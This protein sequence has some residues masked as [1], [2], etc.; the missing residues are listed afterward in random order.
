[1]SLNVY[2]GE[3]SYDVTPYF[4]ELSEY[5]N[6][7]GFYAALYEDKRTNDLVFVIRG[8]DDAEDWQTGNLSR[9]QNEYGLKTFRDIRAK[10]GD[11]NYVAAGHSLGGGVAMHISLHEE[12]VKTYSFNGSPNF[13][14]SQKPIENERYSIVEYGEILKIAR[15]FG[16]EATQLYTSIGC[17][18]GNPKKQHSQLL[19]SRCLT[20]IASIDNKYARESLHLNQIKPEYERYW[21][22]TTR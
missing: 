1:L 2:R 4:R 20:Q 11:R 7:E 3:F 12:G 6:E 18:S 17:S 14:A 22:L 13:K 10:H 21:G 8:T 16:R 9:Q 19:L 5:K 15:I